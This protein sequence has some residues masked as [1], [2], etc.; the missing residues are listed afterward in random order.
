MNT[1]STMILAIFTTLVLLMLGCSP[2]WPLH[3]SEDSIRASLLK[4]TPVGTSHEKVEAYVG[5]W[6]GW[7]VHDLGSQEID[8]DLGAYTTSLASATMVS[9]Q[10]YFDTN[11]CLYKISV[12]KFNHGE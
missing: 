4:R 11:G 10:W 6:R 1:K 3:R 7:T 5:Q 2:A 8:V 12:Q 9:A